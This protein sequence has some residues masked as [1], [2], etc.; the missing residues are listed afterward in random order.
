[1]SET[2]CKIARYENE[3]W[4]AAQQKSHSCFQKG[5]QSYFVTA[6]F[7]CKPRLKDSWLRWQ[8]MYYGSG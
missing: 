4:F 2:A 7:E 5:E 8:I 6:V 3:E 1:M